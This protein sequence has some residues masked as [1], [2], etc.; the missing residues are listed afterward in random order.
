MKKIYSILAGVLV[1]TFAMALKPGDGSTS[2]GLAVVKKNETTVN[3]FYQ[4]AGLSN[5]KVS[6]LD[7]QG[8]EVFSE[9]IKNTDGFIRPYNF[10]GMAEGDYTISVEDKTGKRTEKFKYGQEQVK[11]A[12]ILQIANNK[13]L[14]G[15][16]SKLFS[17]DIKI[18]IYDGDKLVHQQKNEIAGDFGQVFTMKNIF[19]PTFLVTDSK[20]N[21]IN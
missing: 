10:K 20:G 3:L 4:A 9:S 6:I 11:A 5:V 18:R 17:G 7:D 13:Y 21:K 16:N 14:V 12:S 1:S 15:V 2:V 19:E 8:N